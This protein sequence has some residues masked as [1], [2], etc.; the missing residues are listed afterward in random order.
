MRS[1]RDRA[2]GALALLYHPED[3]ERVLAGADARARNASHQVDVLTLAFNH[4]RAEMFVS[5]METLNPDVR[6]LAQVHIGDTDEL[7]EAAR[8]ILSSTAN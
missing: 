5:C 2:I 6:L 8:R 1:A 4:D 7:G 3:F